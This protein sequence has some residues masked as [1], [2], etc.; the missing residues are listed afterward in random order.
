MASNLAL[1]GKNSAKSVAK[2][3]CLIKAKTFLYCCDV[4]DLSILCPFCYK[5]ENIF[6]ILFNYELM[7]YS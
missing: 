3:Q 2:M 5:S 6:L 1:F 4:N 7:L